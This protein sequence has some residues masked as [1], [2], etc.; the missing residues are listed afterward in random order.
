M[1]QANNQAAIFSETVCHTTFFA[2]I[3]RIGKRIALPWIPKE[4]INNYKYWEEFGRTQDDSD[5]EEE[6]DLDNNNNNNNNDEGDEEY[7][8]KPP[9]N[10]ILYLEKGDLIVNLSGHGY[11]PPPGPS[12]EIVADYTFIARKQG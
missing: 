10:S 12:F 9:N 11:T 5:A 2:A 4:T 8:W 1:P 3:Q 7:E 6:E